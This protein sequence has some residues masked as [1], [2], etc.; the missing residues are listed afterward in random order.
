VRIKLETSFTQFLPFMRH[1][2]IG[3]HPCGLY[4]LKIIT[5]TLLKWYN[6]YFTTWYILINPK[7]GLKICQ[8]NSQSERGHLMFSPLT[9]P[10][11]SLLIMWV[12]LFMLNCIFFIHLFIIWMG[13]NVLEVSFELYNLETPFNPIITMRLG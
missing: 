9:L 10:L 5:N 11:Y 2:P 1:M 6:K 3:L 4:Y 8:D 13:F 7:N 12:Y